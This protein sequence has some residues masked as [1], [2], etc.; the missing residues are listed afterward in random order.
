MR[1]CLFFF[2]SLFLLFVFLACGKTKTEV[3]GVVYDPEVTP[4]IH[5]KGVLMLVSDSGITRLRMEAKVWSMYSEAKEPYWYFPEKI[6]AERFDSLFNVEFSVDADTAYYFQPKKLWKLIGNVEVLN[7][8][9]DMF[10]TTELFWDEGK[11][12]V[13]TDK[14]VRVQQKDEEITGIGFLSNQEMTNFR[15]YKSGV[16]LNVKENENRADSTVVGNE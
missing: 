16:L 9:G 13:Y 6:H 3:V 8:E 1:A 5:T 11:K 7:L 10:T 15:F 14:F 4:A 2:Q 12:I